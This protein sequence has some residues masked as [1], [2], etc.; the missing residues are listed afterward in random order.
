MRFSSFCDDQIK[1]TKNR[2]VL[3]TF[4]KQIDNEKQN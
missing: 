4:N 3:N 2:R 1:S